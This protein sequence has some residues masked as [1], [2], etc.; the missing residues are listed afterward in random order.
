MSS[1]CCHICSPYSGR[2]RSYN[3]GIRKEV[4]SQEQLAK[5]SVVFLQGEQAKYCCVSSRTA[6]KILLCSVKNS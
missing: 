4:F 2:K 1:P 6:N 3:K 5:I